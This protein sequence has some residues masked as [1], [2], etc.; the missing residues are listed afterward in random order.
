M[1]EFRDLDISD[2]EKVTQL[3]K[4]SDFMGCEYSFANNLAWRRLNDTKICFYKNF[5]ICCAFKDNDPIFTFPAGSG[6]YREI[7]EEMKVFS[8]KYD[9]ALTVSSVSEKNLEM[10]TEIFPDQ[11]E[12]SADPNYF[13]YIYNTDDLINLSGKKYHQKRNH[14]SKF[15]LNNWSFE[16]ITKNNE[17]ECIEFAVNSYNDK[18]GYDDESSVSEQFAINTFFN[19]YKE[20]GLQGG[21]IRVNGKLEGFTIGEKINSNTL[22]IHIEKANPNIQGSY[23]AINNEFLKFAAKECKYVNREEDLGIEGLR[24]SKRSYYPCFQLVKNTV[25]FRK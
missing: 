6:D 17:N 10:L 12:S 19:Y 4:I 1:L 20:L 13:D 8:A 5:Y 18:N 22:C 15:Y 7:F 3:L 11:F 24:K 16:P 2:K 23:A 21:L 9:A 14:L 25:T